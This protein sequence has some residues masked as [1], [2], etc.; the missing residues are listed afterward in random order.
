[1]NSSSESAK[2]SRSTTARHAAAYGSTRGSSDKIVDRS[3]AFDSPR[4][5]RDDETWWERII[6]IF[7]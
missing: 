5:E 6:D 2:V 4:R 7:D 3:G 1:M